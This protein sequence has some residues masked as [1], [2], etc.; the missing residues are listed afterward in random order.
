MIVK[1]FLHDNIENLV[2]QYINGKFKVSKDISD[3]LYAILIFYKKHIP[4]QTNIAAIETGSLAIEEMFNIFIKYAPLTESGDYWEKSVSPCE[5]WE[6]Y[7]FLAECFLNGYGTAKYADMAREYFKVAIYSVLC[8]KTN[9]K[10]LNYQVDDNGFAK[11]VISG[12]LKFTEYWDIDFVIG[13]M[14]QAMLDMIEKVDDNEYTKMLEKRIEDVSNEKDLLIQHN[15][16]LESRLSK[17]VLDIESLE[18]KLRFA[19]IE[20]NDILQSKE[21]LESD[22]KLKDQQLKDTQQEL[23][24]YKDIEESKKK[25]QEEYA[26]LEKSP[27][28]S[29]SE[30]IIS[31]QTANEVNLFEFFG[32]MRFGNVLSLLGNKPNT[33]SQ[34][35]IEITNDKNSDWLILMISTHPVSDKIGE[36]LIFPNPIPL[37]TGGQSFGNCHECLYDIIN[38]DGYKK[39]SDPNYCI[40]IKIIEPCVVSNQVLGTTGTTKGK[41]ELIEGE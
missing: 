41:I 3:V 26:A 2:K 39:L 6:I 25:V 35:K 29:V 23:Q 12:E 34:V 40:K 1:Y 15:N 24:K 8:G 13:V 10:L 11:P 27:Y 20:K 5:Y 7:Y 22:Y 32:E 31:S 4:E 30:K 18:Q 21:N 19:K 38:E 17:S 36:K 33:N 14:L 28:G 16:V 9:I 37:E